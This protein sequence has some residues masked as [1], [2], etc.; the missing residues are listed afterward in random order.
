MFFMEYFIDDSGIPKFLDHGLI[1][2]KKNDDPSAKELEWIGLEIPAQLPPYAS[3][4]AVSESMKFAQLAGD[5]GYRGY[6]NIDAIVTDRGEVIFNEVNGRWGGCTILHIVA[7]R[8]LGSGYGDRAHLVA[9]RN[10]RTAPFE[11]VTKTLKESGIAFTKDKKEGVIILSC[12]E[13]VD[14]I[15]ECLIL[16]SSRERALELEAQ[17]LKVL[18]I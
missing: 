16:A 6:V 5:L 4:V 13:R 7:E 9:R 10:I 3:A 14:T 12:D 17:L 18:K 1:R 11:T 15:T 8:L 2:L